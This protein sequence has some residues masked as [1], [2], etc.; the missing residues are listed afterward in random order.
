MNKDK[1]ILQEDFNDNLNSYCGYT[2]G[3]YATLVNEGGVGLNISV[4]VDYLTYHI[5]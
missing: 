5:R 4:W 1:N 3:G 2:D